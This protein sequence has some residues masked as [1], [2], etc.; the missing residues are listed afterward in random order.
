MT[1]AGIAVIILAFVGE[2]E[3]YPVV[4]NLVLSGRK[5]A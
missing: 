1:G 4:M 2:T 3:G 5:S